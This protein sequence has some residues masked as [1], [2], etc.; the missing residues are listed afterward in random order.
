VADADVEIITHACAP[1]V[2]VFRRRAWRHLTASS[3]TDAYY[4]T[5][6]HVTGKNRSTA[7]TRPARR[8]ALGNCAWSPHLR[9]NPIFVRAFMRNAML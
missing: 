7:R 9:V 4:S 1:S 5:Y 3:L 6:V 2:S 8:R